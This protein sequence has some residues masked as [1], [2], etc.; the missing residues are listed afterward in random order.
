MVDA[1]LA[2]A[3]YDLTKRFGSTVAIRA[4]DLEVR[5]GERLAVFGPNG[6]GKTT[7]LRMLSG[8]TRPTSGQ[9]ALF[10][11]SRPSGAVY[12]RV[13]V[14][15]HQTYLY[16]DLTAAENL[17]FYA[18]MFGL[19]RP[20]QTAHAALERVGM[21][22]KRRERVST[23]SRGMQQRVALAR[24]LLHDPDILLLDEPDTGLDQE[25]SVALQTYLGL[26]PE[27]G[28]TLIM[29]THNLGLGLRLCQRFAVLAGGRLVH[30]APLHGVTLPQLESTYA[31]GR[32]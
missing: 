32:A 27:R 18:R 15:A 16:N 23:L 28:R 2:V 12:R 19:R 6:S 1:P 29:A 10:G 4:L 7:L 20:E 21:Q 31:A 9:L 13:G 26:G 3:T 25:A 17:A 14:V 22:G 24:A 11:D 5:S 8:L 30:Q